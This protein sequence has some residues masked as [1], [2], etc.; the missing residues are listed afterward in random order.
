MGNYDNDSLPDVRLPYNY[1]VPDHLL[2][3]F[4]KL[5]PN[6]PEKKR[7]GKFN[8]FPAQRILGKEKIY[9]GSNWILRFWTPRRIDIMVQVLTKQCKCN[10]SLLEW[11]CTNWSKE[12][13]VFYDIK[14]NGNTKYFFIHQ[15][16]NKFMHEFHKLCADSY[17]R[18]QRILIEY[19]CNSDI[20]QCTNKS[21]RIQWNTN[22][23]GVRYI[24]GK[25]MVY[26]VT[27]VGQLIFF[28]WAIKNNVVYYCDENADK[29]KVH[30]KTRKDLNKEIGGKRKKLIQEPLKKS[31]LV[32]TP[33]KFDFDKMQSFE[34]IETSLIEGLEKFF[35]E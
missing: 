25:K 33:V 1:S 15:E 12:Y 13:G 2:D 17:G 16:Y 14:E 32:E 30:M 31:L 10:L 24:N 5:Y 35:I 6:P 3:E 26:V 9:I 23:V 34:N 22:V 21:E 7:K 11:C 4:T 18:N 29:I 27:T 20:I 28:H 19:V 8:L